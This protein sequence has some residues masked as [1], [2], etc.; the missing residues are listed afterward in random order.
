MKAQS[1]CALGSDVP[2]PVQSLEELVKLGVPDYIIANL[3][4]PIPQVVARDSR[5][6]AICA[7]HGI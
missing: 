6:K 2:R 5:A 1:F 7:G 4:K 3:R